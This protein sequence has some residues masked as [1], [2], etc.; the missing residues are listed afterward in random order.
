MRLTKKKAIE[1]SI[2][3]WTY[4]AETG[5]D[6]WEW[7]GWEEYG[8][9]DNDCALCEYT[10]RKRDDC[11]SCSYYEKFGYC[12]LEDMPYRMWTW[13]E[14]MRERKKYATQFLN[15]LREVKDGRSTSNS[16]G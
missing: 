1:I 2:E 9:M 13:A 8:E 6:K 15:Q 7:P 12:N 5:N 14:S 3:L 11:D 16:D 10:T 4:L